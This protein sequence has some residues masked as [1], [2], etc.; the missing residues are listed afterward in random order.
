MCTGREGNG[1]GVRGLLRYWS[2]LLL[3]QAAG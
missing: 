1:V 2:P 3:D